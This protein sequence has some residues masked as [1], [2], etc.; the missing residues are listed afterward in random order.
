MTAFGL[1]ILI[2]KAKYGLNLG[3]ADIYISFFPYDDAFILQSTILF[4]FVNSHHV[5]LHLQ[6]QLGALFCAILTTSL[7]QDCLVIQNVT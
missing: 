3:F 6:L 2:Q 1:G 7:K 4:P 5:L